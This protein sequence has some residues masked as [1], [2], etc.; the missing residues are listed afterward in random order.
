MRNRIRSESK[1]GT[2][3]AVDWLDEDGVT[4]ASA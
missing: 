4:D 2:Y 1:E 3:S